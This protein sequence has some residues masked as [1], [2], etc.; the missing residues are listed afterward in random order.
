[1][2]HGLVCVK[3]LENS[4]NAPLITLPPFIVFNT[5]GRTVRSICQASDSPALTLH[6]SRQS[7]HDFRHAL[8]HHLLHHTHSAL[9]EK[10]ADR[11]EA[12][13][14]K[15]KRCPYSGLDLLDI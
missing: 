4:P 10:E 7:W 6:E 3:W 8:G 2:K 9:D 14:S 12:E 13:V 1:M 5:N 11:V 15:N